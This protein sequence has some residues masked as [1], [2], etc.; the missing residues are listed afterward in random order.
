[1]SFSSARRILAIESVIPLTH[2]F[3]IEG[4]I[5]YSCAASSSCSPRRS[6]G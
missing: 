1:M 3:D 4:L 5:C 6:A 2:A